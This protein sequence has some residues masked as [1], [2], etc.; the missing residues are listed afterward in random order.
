MNQIT[1]L[2]MP[3]A[4]VLLSYALFTIYLK[5]RQYT[6]HMGFLA[7]EVEGRTE[8]VSTLS[9][10]IYLLHGER[11][12]F[13]FRCS[14]TPTVKNDP[15]EFAISFYGKF[16]VGLSIRKRETGDSEIVRSGGTEEIQT[17]DGPFDKLFSIHLRQG[18]DMHKYLEDP[19][20]RALIFNFLNQENANLF[21][22]GASARVIFKGLELTDVKPYALREY[23]DHL[24]SLAL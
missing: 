1:Q 9:T 23:L 17:G 3:L 4:A 24:T 6:N 20:R 11:G 8:I 5:V 19:S 2:F 7:G 18:Q 21:F 15:P 16:P 12:K 22:E 14:F 10:R 13:K